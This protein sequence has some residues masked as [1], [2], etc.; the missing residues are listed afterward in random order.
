MNMNM[1]LLRPNVITPDDSSSRW[2]SLPNEHQNENGQ[3]QKTVLEY[4]SLNSLYEYD[5][6]KQHSNKIQDTILGFCGNGN[7]NGNGNG[8][9]GAAK[10]RSPEEQRGNILS[11]ED[12]PDV[13]ASVFRAAIPST[14]GSSNNSIDP[15]DDNEME[16]DQTPEQQSILPESAAQITTTMPVSKHL[17]PNINDNSNERRVLSREIMHN[18][19]SHFG[20]ISLILKDLKL[21]VGGTSG[22]IHI[23]HIGNNRSAFNMTTNWERETI[24]RGHGDR[25][26][27]LESFGTHLMSAYSN[28]SL[29]VT[30]Y[31]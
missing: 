14:P 31:S 5:I 25:V 9:P 13:L 4:I 16:Q 20:P 6:P 27:C 1:N 18:A 15:P 11:N 24:L 22:E 28:G 2:P 17:N 23:W 7:G 3:D 19:S 10:L 30:N 26:T 12:V 29:K 8:V 21:I